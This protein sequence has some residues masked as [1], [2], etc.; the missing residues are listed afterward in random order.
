[1]KTL[2][3]IRPTGKLHL[4]HYFSVIKPAIKTGADV[5]IAK[6]H[7]PFNDPESL[8]KELVFF[9]VAPEQI[10]IQTFD[11]DLYFKL[12]ALTPIGELNRMTQFK[13]QKEKTAHLFVYPVLMAMDVAGY[14]KVIVGED[15]R[16]HL[17]FARTILRKYNKL[18]NKVKIPEGVYTGGRV[19]SLKNPASKMSKSEPDGCLFLTD[20]AADKEHKIK[21]AV[22]DEL[23][24]KNL[25]FLYREFVGGIPPKMNEK[26]KEK[27]SN[28]IMLKFSGFGELKGWEVAGE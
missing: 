7:A 25:E 19:M 8:I 1:M 24:R 6:F 27:L 15:Q 11:P 17:E 13:S 14:D 5:L 2:V 22:T 18:G 12:L 21:K 28:E 4:G 23:G 20:P 16:Q 10:K 3:G 9:R 26:L